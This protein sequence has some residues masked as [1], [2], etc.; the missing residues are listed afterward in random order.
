[1]PESSGKTKKSYL[2]FADTGSSSS[3]SNDSVR[4]LEVKKQAVEAESLSILTRANKNLGKSLQTSADTTKSLDVQGKKLE[5]VLHKKKETRKIVAASETKATGIKRSGRIF[6][7]SNRFFDSVAN[8][9]SLGRRRAHKA[10]QEAKKEEQKTKHLGEQAAVEKEKQEGSKQ[11]AKSLQEENGEGVDAQ[12]EQT[13]SGLKTLRA[14]V[15]SQTQKIKAQRHATKEMQILDK[16]TKGR[17]AK[18]TERVKKL[19]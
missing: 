16:D 14:G 2:S 4:D 7:F 15:R 8:F 5:G 3:S 11:A 19:Q 1:M 17:T 10:E 13:L 12:L 6:D 9:F 18:L